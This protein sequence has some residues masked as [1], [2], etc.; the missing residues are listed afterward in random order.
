MIT[1]KIKR[2][3]I[4]WKHF[5]VGDATCER[6]GNTGEALKIQWKNYDVRLLLRE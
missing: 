3:E 5:A 1:P 4:E 2:L 6:C